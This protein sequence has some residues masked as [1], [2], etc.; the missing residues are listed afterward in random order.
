MDNTCSIA[1]AVTMV[2][3]CAAYVF[4]VETSARHWHLFLVPAL[5]LMALG[6]ILATVGEIRDDQEA[7]AS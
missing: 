2:L 4:D 3:G 7:P 1:G 6:A 5:I